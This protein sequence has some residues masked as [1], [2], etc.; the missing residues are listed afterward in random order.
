MKFERLAPLGG[1]LFLVLAIVSF[2]VLLGESPDSDDSAKEVVDF[3]SEDEGKLIA[4]AVVEAFAAVAFVCFGIAI[5][6]AINAAESSDFLGTLAFGGVLIAATGF[7]IDATLV[8]ALSDTAGDVSPQVTETLNALFSNDFMPFVVGL[9][10]LNLASGVAAIRSGYLPKW[11]GW[12]QIAVF[13][14][15]FAG[16]I[17]FAAFLLTGLWVAVIG[18]VLYR[19]GAA[20]PTTP[21]PGGPGA[22]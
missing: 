19:R 11:F 7:A 9:A 8:F 10:L 1:T 2:M 4:S 15:F 3:W 5:R 18:I 22:L 21:A 20:A 6:R 17:G 12:I 13:V 14:L 16:P